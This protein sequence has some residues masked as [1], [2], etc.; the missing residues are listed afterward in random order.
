MFH[1]LQ[2]VCLESGSDDELPIEKASRKLEKKQKKMLKE[3]EQEMKL[4][5]GE[6]ETITLPTGFD[7]SSLWMIF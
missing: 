4:N 7:F 3:S 2:S 6:T 5:I 1:Y